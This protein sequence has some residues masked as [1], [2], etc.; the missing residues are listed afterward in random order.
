M[1]VRIGAHFIVLDQSAAMKVIPKPHFSC[2]IC[3][4]KTHRKFGTKWGVVV[5]VVVVVKCYLWGWQV[6]CHWHWARHQKLISNRISPRHPYDT[7]STHHGPMWRQSNLV[8]ET[9]NH[10]LPTQSTVSV[11]TY[12]TSLHA[13]KVTWRWDEEEDI[14]KPCSNCLLL[15]VVIFQTS[16]KNQ[17]HGA[18]FHLHSFISLHSKHRSV[19]KAESTI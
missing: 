3:W 11:T 2:G 4:Q 12:S 17:S 19:Q 7:S 16:I 18:C 9:I 6:W 13:E 5:V 15:C 14:Y 8:T 1:E 10:H